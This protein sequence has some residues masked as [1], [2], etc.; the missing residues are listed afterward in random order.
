MQGNLEIGSHYGG[1]ELVVMS[2]RVR[3]GMKGSCVFIF[4]SVI[5]VSAMLI[6]TVLYVHELFTAE[7]VAPLFCE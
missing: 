6:M 5:L 2:E 4:I 1:V 7:G 3:T